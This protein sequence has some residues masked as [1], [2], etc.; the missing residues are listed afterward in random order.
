MAFDNQGNLWACS[1]G[2][3]VPLP[4]VADPET[5]DHYNNDDS[6]VVCFLADQDWHPVTFKLRDTQHGPSPRYQPFDLVIDS[7]DFVYLAAGGHEL[8]TIKSSVW[9]FQLEET[10]STASINHLKTYHSDTVDGYKQ[11]ILNRDG[12]L[13]VANQA[14]GQI[15]KLTKDLQEVNGGSFTTN[16]FSPWG[17]CEDAVG[18]LFV[19]N[20]GHSKT[21]EYGVA[22]IKNG[23]DSATK[24]MTLPS[25]GHEVRLA[26]GMPLYGNASGMSCY[27]PLMRMTCN[28]ID[29]VGNL[30]A[31]NNWK[32]D[33]PND[34]TDNPGGDGVVIFVGVAK[35]KT[36]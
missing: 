9:K 5:I 25:G 3:R 7:D 2:S 10:G 27:K 24:L 21:G 16:I 17:I 6:A 1:W 19:A 15:L 34:V 18:T 35:P 33:F 12:D 36:L 23:E 8:T 26:N 4:D 31:T 20:F 13:L 14:F 28:V 32:P 29:K 11:I 22:V 30:W